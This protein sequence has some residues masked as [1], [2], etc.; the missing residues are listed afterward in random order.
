MNM[1]SRKYRLIDAIRIPFLSAP[2]ATSLIGL[3]ILLTSLVPTLQ[4]IVTAKF[5]DQAIEIVQNQLT[6][7]HIYPSLFTVVALIAFMWIS[8]ELTRFVHVK[9]K[10][11]IREKFRSAVVYKKAKLNFKHIEDHRTWDLISRVSEAPE[12]KVKNAFDQMCWMISTSIQVAGILFILIA[13]V[14]WAALLIMAFSVPLFSL[15]IK[16][17]RATY[18]A[19]REV[20]KYRRKY[21]YLSWV[22]SSRESVDERAL[23]G[24]SRD[25]SNMWHRDYETARL[26]EYKTEK[27]WF[28]KMKTGS[29]L[30]ALISMLIIFVLLNPVLTGAVT[31][32][33]FISLVNAVFGL[34]QKMSWGLTNSV[35][36]LANFHEYLQDLSEFSALD[37]QA[38]AIE[39]PITPAP[40][41]E[42]LEFRQV[43]FT[44][45]GMS[46]LILDHMSFRMTAG[47]HYAFVGVNGAGKTTITKLMTGL[48][49]QFDGEILI[50]DRPIQSYTQAE[51]KAFYSVVYQ[52]F[53]KYYVTIN[54]NIAIGDINSLGTEH[55]HDNIHKAIERVELNQAIDKLSLGLHTPL[56]KIKTEGQ[57]ISGGEWQR[58]AMARAIVNPAPLRIL[59]EPTAALDPLSESKLYEQFE[60]I[61]AGTTTVFISHRLGSTR[62][63]D[64]IFVIDDGKVVESGSH[65][66]LMDLAGIYAQMYDSQRSW[67]DESRA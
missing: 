33:L 62:L 29:L 18:E 37:E 24:Y 15:A 5:I 31:I 45:P 36:E 7:N 22:L 9:Q 65:Q 52:D 41:F 34:V 48:Y 17:G 53:A 59:D 57:D 23:F 4:I 67:Y 25:V 43:S 42:S 46:K 12:D 26:I 44:Y 8:A 56:G 35:D 60:Q 40:I 21:Q 6:L 49:Q 19:N 66:E 30:T 3:S 55:S 16:S 1:T 64:V 11:H 51:L 13:H 54:D 2:V 61:S 38:E 63:A 47:K 28:I 20:T 58:I 10:I 50:N 32:G 27:K 39:K 14:W